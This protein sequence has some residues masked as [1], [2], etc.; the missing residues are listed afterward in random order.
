MSTPQRISAPETGETV[1][2][3]SRLWRVVAPWSI[4]EAILQDVSSDTMMVAPFKELSPIAAADT[5]TPVPDKSQVPDADWNAAVKVYQVIKPLYEDPHRTVKKVETAA[6][7]RGVTRATVYVWL[8]RY[9]DNPYAETFLPQK[10]GIKRGTRLLV[11][12]AE[13]VIADAIEERSLTRNGLTGGKFV[14]L[15]QRICRQSGIKAPCKAA[16]LHR[17]EPFKG[18]SGLRAR[19]G[20]K[21][22]DDVRAPRPGSHD[23]AEPLEEVQIDHTLIDIIAVTCDEHRYVVG[24]PWLTLGIDVCTRLIMGYYLAYEHPNVYS[25]GLATAFA[26]FE[27][28][29]LLRAM[30]IDDAEWGAQGVMKRILLDNA[31]EHKA[32]SYVWA[33]ANR[34]IEVVYREQPHYG[35]HI[36]RLIGTTMRSFHALPGTTRESVE[37]RGDYDSQGTATMTFDEIN[38]F[39]VQK[40]CAYNHAV[41]SALDQS[42]WSLWQAR[43]TRGDP[44]AY[45]PPRLLDDPEKFL[46]DL[47]PYR[48][49]VVRRDGLH[50]FGVP[51]WTPELQTWVHNHENVRV[52]YDPRDIS[53]VYL[54]VPGAKSPLIVPAADLRFPRI[55]LSEWNKR[56]QERRRRGRDPTEL[57]LSDAH[58]ER[59]DAIVDQSV[60]SAAEAKKLRKRVEATR[61]TN[62]TVDVWQKA[63]GIRGVVV[64]EEDGKAHQDEP[65]YT[66]IDAIPLAGNP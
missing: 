5:Q 3:A 65:L 14:K 54:P 55:S 25:V 26:C 58:E 35:G 16:I 19:R 15:V 37:K 33:C 20:R 9:R 22:A 21:Q 46:L 7:A 63:H 24:R 50:M 32:A 29:P 64:T 28:A 38:R 11:A 39:L 27:K 2:W 23:V 47:M 57:A 52:P 45:Q 40:F 10:R 56:K 6:E 59:A 44:P 53:K 61:T 18:Y 13:K 8:A 51:Y 66:D 30:G 60:L 12:V 36:E 49:R 4:T 34:G 62:A 41:H 42:P 17:L 1:Q 48:I 31:R 43:F